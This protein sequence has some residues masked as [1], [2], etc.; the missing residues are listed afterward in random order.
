MNAD[1]KWQWNDEEGNTWVFDDQGNEWYYFADQ[2][3]YYFDS[4]ERAYYWF[5]PSADL[6]YAEWEDGHWWGPDD[7]VQIQCYMNK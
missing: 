1:H 6:V 5:D 2:Y 4:E 7:D 3:A